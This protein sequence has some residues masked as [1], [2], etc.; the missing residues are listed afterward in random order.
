MTLPLPNY[1][2]IYRSFSV[3]HTTFITSIQSFNY[4]LKSK[5][6]ASSCYSPHN[7]K[8]PSNY[9]YSLFHDFYFL[10]L[11]KLNVLSWLTA[12]VFRINYVCE[13]NKPLA[14][15]NR[16]YCSTKTWKR[17]IFVKLL[18]MWKHE[19]FRT[20]LLLYSFFQKDKVLPYRKE[21]S[22]DVIISFPLIKRIISIHLDFKGQL[23]HILTALLTYFLHTA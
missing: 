18:R 17:N 11:V 14:I 7:H 1:L 15:Q 2:Y 9:H 4:Y 5:H 16:S 6:F 3:K 20:F 19:Q 8:I 23:P 22:T 13:I 12:K 21:R 10:E